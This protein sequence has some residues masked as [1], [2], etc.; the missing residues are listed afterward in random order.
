[1][2]HK[3]LA[4]VAV[5]ACFS[6]V[7][8]QAGWPFS[9]DGPP[10]GSDEWYA[11]RATDPVGER[12]V[13]KYGKFWPPQP[14]PTGPKQLFMH[15]YHTQK[16]W[17]MPYVCG[18][19]DAVYSVWNSQAENGWQMMTTLYDYHFDPVTNA[20]N[21]SGQQHL[22]W[23]LQS[24]PA[25]RRRISVQTST[26]ATVNQMRV[27]NVQIAAAGVPGAGPVGD[28]ALRTTPSA[29]RP[30]EEVQWIYEQQQTLRTP[31]QIQYTA[32]ASAAN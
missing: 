1:M 5:V 13:Y 12:R 31:P 21:H 25:E 22:L 32:P 20:L 7:E 28:I 29:G 9:S 6:S 8:L 16:Y 4:A 17:P 18:D 11:L 27:S 10:R 2:L 15:K 19:R 3:S 24:A 30:A 26:D 14:R 23:I